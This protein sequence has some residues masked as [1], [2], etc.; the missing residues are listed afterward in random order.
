MKLVSFVVAVSLLVAASQVNA[1]PTALTMSYCGFGAFYCGDSF[2]DDVYSRSNSVLLA[3]A[4][5]AGN[6]AIIVDADNYPK[7]L[8]TTWR[9]TGKRVVLSIGGPSADWT[10]VYES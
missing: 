8:V 3:Y 6:G 1:A 7:N 9:N 2:N 5:I 4:L 10:R